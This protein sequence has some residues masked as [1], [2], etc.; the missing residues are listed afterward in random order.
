MCCVRP[1]VTNCH[2][3]LQKETWALTSPIAASVA[4]RSK[5]ISS[6]I[7]QTQNRNFTLCNTRCCRGSKIDTRCDGPNQLLGS[8]TSIIVHMR[9]IAGPGCGLRKKVSRT[10]LQIVAISAP[11]YASGSHM[12]LQCSEQMERFLRPQPAANLPSGE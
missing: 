10:S 1:I 2:K 6:P 5:I 4:L 3:Y 8:D 12:L 11:T 7:V 9:P